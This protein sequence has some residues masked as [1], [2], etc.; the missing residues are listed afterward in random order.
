[1]T[2]SATGDWRKKKGGCRQGRQRQRATSGSHTH[3]RRSA[4]GQTGC[5]SL[6]RH[7]PSG[8]RRTPPSPPRTGCCCRGPWTAPG[9]SR[10]Q[11]RPAVR[12]MGWQPLRSAGRRRPSGSRRTGSC[13]A[14]GGCGWASRR[15]RHLR[16]IRGRR[17][18]RSASAAERKGRSPGAAEERPSRSPADAACP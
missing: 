18:S 6:I 3:P 1:M 4:A 8:S 7:L 12:R 14:V 17:C 2:S 15:L 9:G 10:T 13:P 16:R 5:C 11:L